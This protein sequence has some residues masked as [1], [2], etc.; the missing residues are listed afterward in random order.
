MWLWIAGRFLI[1]VIEKLSFSKFR[2]GAVSLVGTQH[3]V[4]GRHNSSLFT[5]LRQNT[6]CQKTFDRRFI[7]TSPLLASGASVVTYASHIYKGVLCTAKKKQH[8]TPPSSTYAHARWPV[9]STMSLWTPKRQNSHCR[10]RFRSVVSCQA[11]FKEKFWER[12]G[13]KRNP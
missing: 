9:D 7:V 13:G 6:T 11:P 10:S 5:S 4:F 12:V 1:A 8:T 2:N 3:S